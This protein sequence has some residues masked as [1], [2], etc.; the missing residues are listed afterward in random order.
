MPKYQNIE[1][2]KIGTYTV[3]CK[4]FNFFNDT[5]NC[6]RKISYVR[7]QTFLCD[8]CFEFSFL[9]EKINGP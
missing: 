6:F 5:K 2:V 7:V 4:Q 9:F 1:W 8:G 3:T